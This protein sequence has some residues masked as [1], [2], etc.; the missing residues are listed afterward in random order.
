M[1]KAKLPALIFIEME[2][3]IIGFL[4]SLGMTRRPG[5][6]ARHRRT[7]VGRETREVCV[8]WFSLGQMIGAWASEKQSASG[9]ESEKW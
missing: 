1:N 6:A 9:G 2:K 3:H 7:A 4:R 8:P 5:W